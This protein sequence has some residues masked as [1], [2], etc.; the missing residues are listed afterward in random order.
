MSKQETC[1]ICGQPATHIRST[2]FAGEH[3]FC[4]EHAQLEKDFGENDSYTYWYETK[5]EYTIDKDTYDA[6]MRKAMIEA[7]QQLALYEERIKELETKVSYMES[8]NR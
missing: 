6:L 1:L 5:E 7:I 4:K 8:Q 2:Q 3:P